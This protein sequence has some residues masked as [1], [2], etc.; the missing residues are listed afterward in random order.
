MKKYPAYPTSLY[1]SYD[2]TALYIV[3]GV[4]ILLMIVGFVGYRIYVRH[5]K[6]K[7]KEILDKINI[8]FV[9]SERNKNTTLK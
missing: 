3:I 1:V 2:H 7:E 5:K 6:K 9:P 8:S 4:V